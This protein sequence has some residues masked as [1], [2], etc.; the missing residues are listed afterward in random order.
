MEDMISRTGKD[1]H[2]T[3]RVR[4]DR[5]GGPKKYDLF[6]QRTL[7]PGFSPL[8]FSLKPLLNYFLITTTGFKGIVF[9]FVI[10]IAP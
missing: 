10:F 1:Y 8:S 7:L 9:V 5:N 6:V 3:G 4:K 2:K